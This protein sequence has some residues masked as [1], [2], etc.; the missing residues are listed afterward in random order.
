MGK[1]SRSKKQRSRDTTMT[2]N[3]ARAARAAHR[4]RKETQRLLLDNPW[5]RS[6]VASNVSTRMAELRTVLQHSD[7][8]EEHRE[9]M[10]FTLMLGKQGMR[11]PWPTGPVETARWQM[12]QVLN[13]LANAEVLVVSPAAHAAVMAATATLEPAD[14]ATLDRDRDLAMPTGLLVLPTSVVVANRGGSLSDIRAFGWQMV[15]QSQML[16]DARYPGIQLT[17]FMD[18]DGPVQPESWRLAV[19]QAR[20]SGA[21]LPPLVPDGMYGM[22]GDGALAAESVERH[23][24]LTKEHRWLHTALNEVA[25]YNAVPPEEGQWDGGRIEDV[26]DDFA[27]RYAFAFWR[28]SAQGITT[29][30]SPREQDSPERQLHSVVTPADPDIRVIRLAHQVPEQ[31][32]G[33]SDASRIYHHRWTV[34]MHKVRQWYPSA[35]EHRVIWRGPYIKGPAD[36]PFMVGEKAYRVD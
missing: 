4:A 13:V 14:M 16:P 33:N 3:A 17:C 12:Q 26:Y 2:W 1:A 23:A 24:A 36:A 7:G 20:A 28:L 29:I 19:A 21:P 27:V 9:N 6:M 11:P 22:R 25:Q 10:A 8:P 15:T 5:V 32:T 35:Q 34:R 31:R 30:T 18:R